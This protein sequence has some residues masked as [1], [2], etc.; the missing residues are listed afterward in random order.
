MLQAK[1]LQNCIECLDCLVSVTIGEG[2]GDGSTA[3]NVLSYER[4]LHFGIA[5]TLKMY[6]KLIG[7]YDL[8]KR[9]RLPLRKPSAEWPHDALATNHPKNQVSAAN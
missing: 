9:R 3:T 4:V 8:L 1:Y 6:A 2:W 7:F 5:R